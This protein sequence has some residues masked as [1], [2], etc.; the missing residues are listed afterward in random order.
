M[1][2]RVVPVQDRQSRE[3][4][5]RFPW[6]IYRDDHLWV[7]PLVRSQLHTLDP[8]QGSFFRYGDAALFLAQRDGLDV[9]RI[10]G[11][12]NHR[13][14]KFLD[15]KAAGFGFFETFNDYQVAQALLDTVC[16]W[17]RGQG[18][19]TIR[20]PFYFSMDD[21]PGV[22]I[23]GFDRPPVLLCGHSPPYYANLLEQYGLTKYRDAYASRIDLAVFKGDVAN[24]PSKVLRVAE[25]ARRRTGVQIRSM[26]IEN[27]DAEVTRVI[28]L[29]NEAM[30]HMRNHVPM[31][32]QEFIRFTEE[33]RQVID[34]DLVFFAEIDGQPIGFSATIPDINQAL[35]GVNGHLFPLG[36]LRLWWRM[37]H[38]DAASLK[39]LAVLEEHRARGLDS[40]LYIETA[41]VLLRKGYAW[42]DLS[43]TAE[44]N[45]AVNLLVQHLGGQRYKVYRTYYTSLVP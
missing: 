13:A 14:N 23:E 45:T 18:M 17:A 27:W 38:T 34:P 37:R 8:Q 22:L 25:A 5:V 15:E 20:G 30:G 3:R 33:L 4:F 2:I 44:N 11:W 1:N 9:G 40:L 43:L 12:I 36:W 24:L 41:R 16:D 29:V 7:P 39:L 19:E 26:C 31:G 32:E 10:A 28:R 21:S 35:K 42:V 6:Q